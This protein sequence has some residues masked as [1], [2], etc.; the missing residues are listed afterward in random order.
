MK[1]K[2]KAPKLRPAKDILDRDQLMRSRV[3]KIYGSS[4]LFVV[5]P[6]IMADK[7]ATRH[8]WFQTKI[9]K[10]YPVTDGELKAKYWS[11][12]F[13]DPSDWYTHFKK[14]DENIAKLKARQEAKKTVA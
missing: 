10:D 2:S 3:A 14:M 1:K 9:G 13:F 7:F 5:S 11:L 4:I 8:L 6:Q 12:N